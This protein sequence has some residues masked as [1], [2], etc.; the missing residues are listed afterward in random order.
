MWPRRR[1]RT[2]RTPP[3]PQLSPSVTDGE[4]GARGRAVLVAAVVLGVALVVLAVH[5]P[6]LS[7][8]ALAFDDGEFITNNHVVQNPSW[9]SAWRFT[10]EVLEPT[11]V[12]GYYIPLTM[13][14]LMLDYGAGGR[15]DDLRQFHRTNLGLH[16][17]ST[18][19]VVVLLYLLFNQ[20][21]VAAMLGLLYG[22]HPLTVE[23]IAWVGERKTVLATC[24][25]LWS[26]VM[27]VPYA[28]KGCRW[29]YATSMLLFALSL[30]AKPTTVPLPVLMLI[31]DYW[32]LRRISR[33]SVFEKA[34]YFILAGVS[35]VIT[36]ISN[37]RTANLSMPAD[38]PMAP[39][40]L[41]ICHNLIFYLRKIVWPGE[42][43]SY[44]PAPD[45]FSLSHP[46]V[47]A[48]VV[49]TGVVL[50]LI[51]WSLRWTR[52][53]A[54][55]SLFFLAALFPTLGI[56]GFS[57]INA[58]DKYLYL[59]AVGLLLPLAW[60]LCRL[61]DGPLRK[62]SPLV[63][64]G[65]IA[66]GVLILATLS[67]TGTRRYL[68]HW[69]TSETLYTHMLAV[70]PKA[71]VLH[72]SLAADL[73]DQGRFDES[74]T[75]Y[76]QA[77]R[78]APGMPDVHVG[79]GQALMR[80]GNADEAI[81]QYL[82]ALR[83]NPDS[84]EAHNNLGSALASQKKLEE[85]AAQHAEALRLN[86]GFLQ[87]YINLGTIRLTQGR[88]EEAVEQFTAALSVNPK[89]VEAHVNLGVALKSMGR[90][91]EA[92]E[93]YKAALQGNPNHP[94]IHRNIA[95]ALQAQGKN[96]EAGMYFANALYLQGLILEGRGAMEA[97]V[98]KYREALRLVP[99]HTEASKR[100]RSLRSGQD[101]R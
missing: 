72:Y 60:W 63:R 49:G 18:A 29:A 82:E 90:L 35:A 42:L 57:W 38:I 9:A 41:K 20:P 3:G 33:R 21:W 24:F 50:V 75:H 46:A 51:L 70:A 58:S 61:W 87:A 59:P 5:W 47:L 7:A 65:A 78:M 11:T 4:T 12:H 28:R 39:T 91:D 77:V 54:A 92:I 96:E 13:I 93:H 27:Y 69:R 79:L 44:Y 97:A 22:L 2:D 32:P 88:L 19:G 15:P 100:L 6:V 17:L 45:P 40:V 37:A 89:S 67:A 30:L 55:G 36:V 43:T 8:Q 64:R 66:L 86:P 95:L 23:S 16:V 76:R 31:L 71:S 84:A 48:G 1:Q 94:E 34:P 14:S 25:A 68:H 101:E 99:K 81:Q 10:R 53:P 83:I 56:I 74:V 62:V 73:Y 85:A 98:A 52:A 80:Q 26:L